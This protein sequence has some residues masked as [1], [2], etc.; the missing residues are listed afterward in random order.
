MN[1]E[2]SAVTLDA[3]LLAELDAVAAASDRSRDDILREAIVQYL[4]V[5]SWQTERIEAGLADIR[6]GRVRPA[7]TVFAEIAAKHGWRL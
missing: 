5:R 3:D 1:H 6:E 4:D 7:E 2:A